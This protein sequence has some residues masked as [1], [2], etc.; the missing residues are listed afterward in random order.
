MK[1]SLIFSAVVAC[2]AAIFPLT[3]NV[4]GP[5]IVNRRLEA[6]HAR[7]NVNGLQLGQRGDGEVQQAE[8][9]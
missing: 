1:K 3:L 2:V 9:A 6:D 5:K 7:D 8:V 4:F